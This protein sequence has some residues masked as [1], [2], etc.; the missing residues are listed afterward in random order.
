MKTMIFTLG[1]TA[2]F[3]TSC[4]AYKEIQQPEFRDVQNVRLI[5]MGLLESKAGADLVFYNPNAFNVTLTSARGDIYVDNKYIGRFETSDKVAI[6]KRNEF[7]IPT[8]LKLDNV[9]LLRD[10]N[11]IYKKKEVLIRVDG[12]ARFN[13]SGIGKEMP[14]RYERMESV[15]KLRTIFSR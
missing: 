1:I 13:K 3:L 15:D 9:S 4:K 2:I 8:T 10:Q 11:E 12:T 6:K 14:I 5:D 7:I